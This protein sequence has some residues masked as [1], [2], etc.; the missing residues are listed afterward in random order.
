MDIWALPFT[1]S[2]SEEHNKKWL[3]PHFMGVCSTFWEPG[4]SLPILPENNAWVAQTLRDHTF[5][6]PIDHSN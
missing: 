5:S 1:K 2:I 4:S 6:K 3:L